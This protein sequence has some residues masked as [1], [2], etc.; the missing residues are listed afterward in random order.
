[1][2]LPPWLA[3]LLVVLAAALLGWVLWA[4][5]ED[6]PEE[7]SGGSGPVG[8]SGQAGEVGGAA[9][10]LDGELQEGQQR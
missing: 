7:A 6:D 5:S 2:R 4:P 9:E 10:V 3:G 1:M 8:V